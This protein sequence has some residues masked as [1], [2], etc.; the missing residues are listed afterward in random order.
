MRTLHLVGITPLATDGEHPLRNSIANNTLARTAVQFPGVIAASWTQSRVDVLIDGQSPDDASARAEMMAEAIRSECEVIT[1]DEADHSHLA[2]LAQQ[3]A[4]LLP[5]DVTVA[6]I[7]KQAT[8][9][10]RG[11]LW[12]PVVGFERLGLTADGLWDAMTAVTFQ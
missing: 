2:G 11:M 8:H 12:S 9:Q 4:E 10:M 3:A 7:P 6:S 1:L 5:V